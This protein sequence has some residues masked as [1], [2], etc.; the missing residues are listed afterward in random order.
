[1]SENKMGPQFWMIKREHT[2]KLKFTNETNSRIA[3]NTENQICN[4]WLVQ[5]KGVIHNLRMSTWDIQCALTNSFSLIHLIFVAS[6]LDRERDHDVP[7]FFLSHEKLQCHKNSIKSVKH[8]IR[9]QIHMIIKSAQMYTM[10]VEFKE[11]SIVIICH[12]LLFFW[13]ATI[14]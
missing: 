14:R 13:I 9:E 12:F 7:F 10:L 1:M 5:I 2:K 11:N 8:W 6:Q 3:E 4:S